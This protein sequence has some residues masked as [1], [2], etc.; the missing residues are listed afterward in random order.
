MSAS[1][2][3]FDGF[4]TAYDAA[5]TLERS[6]GFFLAHLPL[7]RERVLDA[8]CGS[9]LLALELS[10]HFRGVVALDISEPML[11]IARRKRNAPNIEYQLC[12]V[13]A[14]S[15]QPAFDA[16]V[17]HTMLHHLSDIPAILEKFRRWLVP[18]GSLILLDC[19][20]RAPGFVPRW[21]V[22]YRTCASLQFAL[23]VF[24]HNFSDALT[25]LRFRSCSAWIAHQQS[26]RYF[27]PAQFRELYAA[28]LPGAQ[29]TRVK[30]LMGVLWNASN[31][32]RE[33]GPPFAK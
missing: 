5:V 23:D 31:R 29:F 8:G 9:G 22:L 33:A 15:S 27:S 14:F 16:I 17:S 20:A 28:S 11:A 3:A 1:A 10:R 7:R 25:L 30:G 32:G 6:H 24:R 4:A 19:V 18:G 13:N 12:D 2:Q 26:D 21:S